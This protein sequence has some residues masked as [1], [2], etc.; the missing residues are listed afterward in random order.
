MTLDNEQ[1][2]KF[3][4]DMMQ[5]V[6]F[7]GSILDVAHHVKQAIVHANVVDPRYPHPVDSNCPHLGAGGLADASS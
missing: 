2:R 7:P 6:N 5:Q 4:I 1:Q 3:L